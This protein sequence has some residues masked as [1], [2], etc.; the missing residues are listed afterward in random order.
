M[1]LRHFQPARPLLLLALILSAVATV[2]S[3][4][5]YKWVDEEGNV[6]Y[7][8]TPPE[9]VDYER[10]DI[11]SAP[12]EQ[13]SS[14]DDG[15]LET[16]GDRY[17]RL[18]RERE[19]AAAER[20]AE[21]KKALERQERCSYLRKQLISLQQQ[22]PVYRDEQGKYRT[23][24][25]YD[26]YEGQREYLDDEVRKKE[27]TR[28]NQEIASVCE[29]PGSRKEQAVAAWERMREKRCEYARQK[30]ELLQEEG[31]KS[32]RQDIEEAQAEV[33]QYCDG[34]K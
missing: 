27:I 15:Q 8:D 10:V 5:I 20:A 2:A 24:S 1:L 17:R 16:A 18:V 21:Q 13:A 26:A 28:I 30:L 3:A 7:C 32:A 33:D 9:G 25:R 22:L 11:A 6:H 34:Q 14:A 12:C 4:D 19:A 31:S 29:D 23:L